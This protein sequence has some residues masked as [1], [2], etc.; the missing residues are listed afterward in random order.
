[1]DDGQNSTM[2]FVTASGLQ[3]DSKVSNGN[4]K[5]YN[6]SAVWSSKI[7]INDTNWT[8]EMKIPYRAIR[9]SNENVQSWG[10][11]LHRET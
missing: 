4:N 3:I 9:F 7:K 11:N 10:M 5:D 1:Y 2:F 8:V 6:W